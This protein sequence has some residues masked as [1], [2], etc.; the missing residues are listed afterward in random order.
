M[1]ESS[2]ETVPD[3]LEP[4]NRAFFEFNDK[5]YF[6][7]LKPVATGYKT[8]VPEEARVC[9]RN[10]FQQFGIPCAVREQSVPREILWSL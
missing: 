8:V 2:G 1:F 9:V 3:P 4:L 7:V 6:W 5:L 10:F